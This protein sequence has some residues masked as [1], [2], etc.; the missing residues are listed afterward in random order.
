MRLAILLQSRRSPPASQPPHMA[1]M[2]FSSGTRTAFSQFS[3]RAGRCVTRCTTPI[4]PATPRYP[5]SAH[6]KTPSSTPPGSQT[7]Y[8]SRPPPATPPS[9]SSTPKHISV[10]LSVAAPH[11]AL[12]ASVCSTELVLI[13][14]SCRHVVMARFVYMICER[15]RC[16]SRRCVPT[17]FINPC[18]KSNTHTYQPLCRPR[19]QWRLRRRRRGVASC[20][21]ARTSTCP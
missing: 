3:T 2:P 8:A 20:R 12:R 21:S 1:D 6:T 5:V 13:R 4:T 10:L 19:L 14:S 15:L 11:K 18:W 7:I 9:V 17:R 16:I